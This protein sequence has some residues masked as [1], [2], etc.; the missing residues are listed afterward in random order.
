MIGSV[1]KK[2]ILSR[3]KG[4]LDSSAAK[5]MIKAGTT[6]AI[7]AERLNGCSEVATSSILCAEENDNSDF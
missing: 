1:R 5:V 7:T 4:D 3:Q 2:V 6:G